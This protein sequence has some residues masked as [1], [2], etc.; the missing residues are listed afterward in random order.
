MMF[1]HSGI[2]T[3]HASLNAIFTLGG[4]YHTHISGSSPGGWNNAY[5]RP[6]PG[7]DWF[8]Q[9]FARRPFLFTEF[10]YPPAQQGSTAEHFRTILF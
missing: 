5:G 6:L 9:W 7:V 10:C 8:S 2:L 3:I 4:A 1:R